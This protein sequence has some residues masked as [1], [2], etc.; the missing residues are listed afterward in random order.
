MPDFRRHH[1]G[2]GLHSLNRIDIEIGKRRAAL[3]R[4]A[5]VCAIRGENGG[6]AALPVDRKLLGEIGGAIGVGHGACGEQQQLAEIALVQ[7]EV[8]DFSTGQS[9]SAAALRRRAFLSE[10]H[11]LIFPRQFQ[12]GG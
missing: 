5:R 8:R 2:A 7:R 3:F 10:Q 12:V 4:I 9:F 11:A 1:S 6:Y